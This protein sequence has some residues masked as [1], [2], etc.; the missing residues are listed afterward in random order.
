MRFIRK[1]VFLW[2]QWHHSSLLA[3]CKGTR[4]N[5]IV[6]FHVG[7]SFS[8]FPPNCQFF[9]TTQSLGFP[10][11]S[12]LYYNLTFLSPLICQGLQ[13]LFF[14]SLARPAVFIPIS[15]FS[16]NCLF[17]HHQSRFSYFPFWTHRWDPVAHSALCPAARNYNLTDSLWS[18]ESDLLVR[19]LQRLQAVGWGWNWS[20]LHRWFWFPFGCRRCDEISG[21][22]ILDCQNLS[23]VK[24]IGMVN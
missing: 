2:L 18:I 20:Y 22:W 7:C 3:C 1:A 10:F 4:F 16:H 9:L 17:F 12:E 13:R 14:A 19:E 5:F 15:I 6:M 11:R 8:I 21:S 23:F 24:F